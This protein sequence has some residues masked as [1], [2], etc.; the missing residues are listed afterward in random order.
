MFPFRFSTGWFLISACALLTA[1]AP[2]LESAQAVTQ[3]STVTEAPVTAAPVTPTPQ[4]TPAEPLKLVL[5]I[6]ENILPPDDET[7]NALFEAEINEYLSGV[8]DLQIDVRRKT[9]QDV[10]GIMST[11]RTANS[12]AP[13]ALPD[14][15]LLRREDLLQAVEE[16]LIQPLEGRIASAIIADLFPAALR[17][18]RAED[19]LYGL[20]YLL[21]LYLYAYRERDIMPESWTFDALLERGD[22]II[23]P[24][25][26]PNGIADILWLQYTSMLDAPVTNADFTLEPSAVSDLLLAYEKL[27]QAGL[28]APNAAERIAPFEYLTP[29]MD[30]RIDSG[31]INTGILRFLG[32]ANPPLNYSA[33]PNRDGKSQTLVNGWMW[34]IVTPNA[35]R[36]IQVG[37]FLNWMMDAGRHSSY[38]QAIAMPPAQ[39]SSLRRWHIDGISNTLLVEML[40]NSMPPQPHVGVTAPARAL[41]AAWIDVI[42]GEATA[43]DA[44]EAVLEP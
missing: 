10:G 33:V 12:V 3:T 27:A 44:I 9:A 34:V 1:C 19:Q 43:A 25:Y 23:F 16:G 14:I 6:P 30:G 39:R 35:E 15:T 5:W 4:V 31:I 20:P 13:G 8:G 18:G 22:E 38:A 28:I 41:Q 2:A 36:Q 26:R 42:T 37:R 17:I 21:D 24:A 11:L 32:E 29:L 7:L 40:A